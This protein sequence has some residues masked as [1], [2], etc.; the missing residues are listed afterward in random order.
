[1]SIKLGKLPFN[2]LLSAK[3]VVSSTPEIVYDILCNVRFAGRDKRGV[4]GDCPTISTGHNT[5]VDK[6]VLA[7]DS[8]GHPQIIA[9]ALATARNRLNSA[10]MDCVV[11][12]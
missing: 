10:K 4:G 5:V 2:V 1:M 7:G 6:I 12:I 3:R 9:T 11:H 8:L